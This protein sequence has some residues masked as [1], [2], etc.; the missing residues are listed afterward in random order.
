MDGMGARLWHVVGFRYGWGWGVWD[1][2][3][4]SSSHLR[5]PVDDSRYTLDLST[6][7][8]ILTSSTISNFRTADEKSRHIIQYVY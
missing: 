7:T 5:K 6:H 1:T 3:G 2:F 8:L 4:E